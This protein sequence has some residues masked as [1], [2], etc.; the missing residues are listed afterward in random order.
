MDILYHI[1]TW[2]RSQKYF[3]DNKCEHRKMSSLYTALVMEKK[4]KRKH[5]SFI[6]NHL[7]Y[8]MYA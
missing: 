2:L 4:F 1:R 3:I 8:T 7:K 5:V 6:C